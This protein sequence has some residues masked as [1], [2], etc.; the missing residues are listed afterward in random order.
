MSNNKQELKKEDIQKEFETAAED[1]ENEVEQEIVNVRELS[2]KK[3][4]ERLC[5]ILK[6]DKSLTYPGIR[7]K[8]IARMCPKT[9]NENTVRGNWPIWMNYEKLSEARQK[10][11]KEGKHS[12]NAVDSA[13]IGKDEEE[14]EHP[15]SSLSMSDY[16][17]THPEIA[18]SP[19]QSL[20]EINR[21]IAR[22]WT[23]LTEKKDMPTRE[24]H[25]KRDHIIPTRQYRKDIVAGSSQIEKDFLYNWLTWLNEA[26]ND[27]LEIIEK[28]TDKK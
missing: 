13:D 6:R 4:I 21:A 24:D 25:I 26:T 19:F 2:T 16:E 27:M 17:E 5:N 14:E 9:W 12:E 11:W 10:D 22:L 1:I 7:R 15:V 28:E 3:G 8:V 18:K 23:A 20:G